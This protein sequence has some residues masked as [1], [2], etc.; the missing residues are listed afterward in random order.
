[1]SMLPVIRFGIRLGVITLGVRML[2]IG[3]LRI[4]VVGKVGRQI[5]L[6]VVNA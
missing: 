5:P 3:V 2:L 6:Q 4:I 1:M